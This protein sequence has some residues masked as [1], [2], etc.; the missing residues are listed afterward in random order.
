MLLPTNA[1]VFNDIN[2]LQQSTMAGPNWDQLLDAR[3]TFKLLYSL[4][5]IDTLLH[6]LPTDSEEKKAEKLAWRQK[7]LTQGGLSHLFKILMTTNF[8]DKSRGP[9]RK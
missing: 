7:F 6:A 3:S 2:T 1:K 9:K 8:V 5:L 4:Q